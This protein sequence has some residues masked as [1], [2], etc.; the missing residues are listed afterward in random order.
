MNIRKYYY[1][2]SILKYRINI[3][4]IID[5]VYRYYRVYLLEVGYIF[6]DIG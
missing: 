5:L 4:D 2:Y 3:L 6:D 1:K